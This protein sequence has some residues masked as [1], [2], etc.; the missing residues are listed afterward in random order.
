[1]GVPGIGVSE[2]VSPELCCVPGIVALAQTETALE[3]AV[4]DAYATPLDRRAAGLIDLLTGRVTYAD[5]FDQRFIDAVPEVQFDAVTTG[6]L[7]GH[8][9]PL[10][11]ESIARDS[12]SSGTASSA[13]AAWGRHLSQHVA[14][15]MTAGGGID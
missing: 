11:V 15:T 10:R 14:D 12:E 1:M 9:Q 5:F 3:I 2:L 8:G 6:L 4:P 7:A 13:M